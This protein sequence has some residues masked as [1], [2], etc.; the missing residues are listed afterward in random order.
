MTQGHAKG[1]IRCGVVATSALLLLVL[2][3]PAFAHERDNAAGIFPLDWTTDQVEQTYAIG[4]FNTFGL[5]VDNDPSRAG[6]KVIDGERVLQGI[7]LA[8]AVDDQ[9]AFDVDETIT[10]EVEL[11]VTNLRE[12]YIAYDRNGTPD[13]VTRVEVPAGSEGWLTLSVDLERARFANRG[14]GG[15]D[16]V[17]ASGIDMSSTL[18][19]IRSIRLKRSGST[20]PHA[21]AG[22]I[23]IQIRDPERGLLLAAQVGL[24]DE[25]G[26]M[27]LPSGHAIE[28]PVFNTKTRVVEIRRELDMLSWPHSNTY[29]MY[30]DG[31]Y[32]A[33]VPAG[34]Y[35]IVAAKGPEYPIVER[36]VTVEAGAEQQVVIDLPHT[37]DMPA[38]GWYSGDVHN[39]FA[40]ANASENPLNAARARA[41]G[42]HMHWLYALG[43]SEATYFNQYAW[44]EDGE[45]RERDYYLGSGQEDPRTDFLG[46]VLAMGQDEFV[47]FPQRY[48]LYDQVSRT[49]HEQGGV[50]GVAHMDFAQFQQKVALA[51]LAP[52]GEIDFVEV[53]QYGVLNLRD[54]YAFL[55]LGFEL[56]AA[57][58]SDWPYMSLPGSVRTFVRV[59]GEF[60]PDRWNAGLKAGRS[61]V[62]NGPMLDL[63]V[64]GN[65][66]GSV[67]ETP[68][69]GELTIVASASIEPSWDLLTRIELIVNGEVLR[70]VDDPSGVTNLELRHTIVADHSMWI[71]VK[72]QGLRSQDIV[73]QTPYTKRVQAHSSP[74]Y[75]RVDG[76]P[77]WNRER[78]PEILDRLIERLERFKSMP[79]QRNDNEAWESPDRTAELVDLSRPLVNKWVD[80]TIEF[81][82]QRKLD[83]E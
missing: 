26:R 36:R 10:A 40:R 25:T 9:F 63:A 14:F 2:A 46:H 30:V 22:S 72:A 64:D 70:T 1:S 76:E 56:P 51:L 80:R 83:I 49:V 79:S 32:R 11:D 58:G 20:P 53:M 29:T 18:L 7:A 67:I 34:G 5:R 31:F 38:A 19:F 15:T 48:L 47:R 43:N 39:H 4:V 69:G 50:F 17:L 45:Y 74:V 57:A 65:G 21:G 3:A 66:M 75:V 27:P 28:L 55:D 13:S 24:Y 82:S 37:L 68:A 73:F 41:H 54:W 16:L 8:F 81:Y 6:V 77:T 42:L 44:G 33:T 23:E 78:A 71:A 52:M 62:S 60:S 59:D 12:F 61:F 35:T